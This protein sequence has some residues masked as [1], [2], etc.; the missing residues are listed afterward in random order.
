MD[1]FRYSPEVALNLTYDWSKIATFN[2]FYKLTGARKE[3]KVDDNKKMSLLGLDSYNWADITATRT[4]IKGLMGSI[5]VR[6][7]FDITT[8]RNTGSS[9]GTHN[10]GT[11]STQMACGR[12]YFVGLTYNFQQ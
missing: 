2:V 1:K 7:L 10:G 3:Y 12:S 9:G 8:V 5:G 11:G 6:N 4:I